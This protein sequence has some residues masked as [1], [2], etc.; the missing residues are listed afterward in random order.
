[1]QNIKLL[2]SQFSQ[3]LY[4]STFFIWF[5]DFIA[6]GGH[7][8]PSPIHNFSFLGNMEKLFW[9]LMTFCFNCYD[10]LPTEHPD[11]E[12]T[13]ETLMAMVLFVS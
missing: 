9:N 3:N 5:M 1:M 10:F 11:L 13:Q 2:R 8:L 6:I 7:V 12:L 4:T